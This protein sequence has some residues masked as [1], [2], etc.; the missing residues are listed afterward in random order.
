MLLGNPD[1]VLDVFPPYAGK[2]IA[3]NLSVFSE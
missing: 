1:Q 3:K 2:D